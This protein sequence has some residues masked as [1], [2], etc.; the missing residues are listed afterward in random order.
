VFY[1]LGLGGQQWSDVGDIGSWCCI[2]W[3]WEANSGVMWGHW[4]LVLYWLGLGGQQC[5]DVGAL[6]VGV[7]LVGLGRPTVE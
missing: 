3:A 2:G 4:Y 6:V 5:S 7:A 1:W